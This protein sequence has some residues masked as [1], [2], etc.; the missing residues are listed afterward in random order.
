MKTANLQVRIPSDLRSDAN[1]VFEELG[2]DMG[3]GI[4]LY[5][6]KVVRTR[7]IPFKV[8]VK[9]ENYLEYVPVDNDTQALMDKVGVAL[10]KALESR[11]VKKCRSSYAKA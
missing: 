10:D 2:L 6:K 5:L 9:D 4:K 8:D 1:D 7:S 11:K 3:T